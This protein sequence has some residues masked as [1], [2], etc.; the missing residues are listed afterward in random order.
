MTLRV[1]QSR[2]VSIQTTNERGGAEYANVDLL[3][4]LVASEGTTSCCS[5]T[6]GHRGR[7]RRARATVE[8]GPKLS[9]G[10]FVTDTAWKHR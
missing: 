5:P 2:I 9:G 6:S 3:A 7:H 10:S 8:L 1:R 4:A